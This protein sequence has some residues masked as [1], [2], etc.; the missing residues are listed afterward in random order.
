MSCSS[1]GGALLKASKHTV[2]AEGVGSFCEGIVCT[3]PKLGYGND[4][5]TKPAL[6]Q[7]CGASDRPCPN[8]ANRYRALEST[9]EELHLTSMPNKLQ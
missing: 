1:Q 5:R 9:A 2:S 6:Q 4:K 3:V 7:S 8:R